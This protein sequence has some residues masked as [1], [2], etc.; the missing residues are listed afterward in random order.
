[1]DLSFLAFAYLAGSVSTV[2]PCGFAMLPAF[3]SFV[4][5]EP[6]WGLE[7]APAGMR[8]WR[9]V[10][11]AGAVTAAFV[12]VF[13][14][15]G[16]VVA[17]VSQTVVGVMPWLALAV[18]VAVIAYGVA[19]LAGRGKIGAQLPNPVEGRHSNRSAMLFGVGFAIASLSC[20][21]PVFTAV[22]ASSLVT[23]GVT[24]GVAGFV[25][26]GVGMGT[27]V[28]VVAIS[29]AFARDGLVR[30][31][32][33]QARH[34]R[35]MSGTVLVLAGGYIVLYWSAALAGGGPGQA[36]D[37]VK[38]VSGLSATASAFLGSGLGRIVVVLLTVGVLAAVVAGLAGRRRASGQ[39]RGA[40]GNVDDEGQAAPARP[41]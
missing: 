23:R 7:E 35:W 8:L 20:T 1:M 40:A 24:G 19:V 10:R 41:Q 29:V 38:T 15:V 16:F 3:A 27:I 31:L 4:I 5:G 22:V 11:L 39:A 17:A 12:G 25:A 2:N 18:G 32:R 9:A 21:L 34:L 36:S 6:G 14:A 33:R 28:A 26:Y 37:V 30:W 13:A